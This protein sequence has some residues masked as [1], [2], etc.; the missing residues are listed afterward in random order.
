MSYATTTVSQ[1]GLGSD[2]RLLLP[3]SPS[4][5]LQWPG[6]ELCCNGNFNLLFSLLVINSA[7]KVQMLALKV[8]VSEGVGLTVCQCLSVQKVQYVAHQ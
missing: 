7:P 1:R 2:S 4:L 3:Y 6:C 8:P 5:S